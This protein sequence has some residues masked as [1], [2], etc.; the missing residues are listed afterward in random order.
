MPNLARAFVSDVLH[1]LQEL[2]WGTWSLVSL[3]VSLA[4]G[5]VVGLQYDYAS[6]F[7]SVSSIDLIVPF[8]AFFRSLHFYSSQLFFFLTCLHLVSAY[9]RTHAYTHS[10]WSRLVGLLPVILLLL[11]TGY[12][13][14]GDNTGASAGIIAENIVRTIP[15]TGDLLNDLLFSAAEDGLRKVYLH[16]V[17]SLDIVLLL[18]AWNH[19]RSYRIKF[20]TQFVPVMVMVFISVVVAAPLDPERPGITYISGPWFFL[21]LQELL[22]YLSPLFAGVVVPASFVLLTLYAQPGTRYSTASLLSIGAWLL[23]Y[24]ALSVAA[25]CR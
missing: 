2:K 9:S 8:G 5:I 17:I 13:L 20:R 12:V 25:W 23:C 22:R 4:S 21:G 19:L 15:F 7:Y 6:A 14:R 18:L 1:K 11:F 16:H 3:Y 10:E 24:A